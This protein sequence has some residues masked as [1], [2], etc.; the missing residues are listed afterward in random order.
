[1]KKRLFIFRALP[2]NRDSRV[3]R[4]ENTQGYNVTLNTWEDQTDKALGLDKL[5]LDRNKYSKV[6]SYPLY[7]IYLFLYSLCKI[8]NEDDVICM[9]LDTFLPVFIGSFFKKNKIYFDIVDPIAE[10]KFKGLWFNFIF[11]YMEIFLLKYRKYNIIPNYNRIKYY[12]DKYNIKIKKNKFQVIENIPVLKKNE[13]MKQNFNLKNKYMIGYFGT[14]EKERGLVELINYTKKKNITLLIAGDGKL[15]DFIVKSSVNKN[16]D[17]IGRYKS[18]DIGELFQKINFLWAYYSD[19][20]FLHKYASPNKYYEH[21]AFKT[22]II[23]NKYVPQSKLVSEFATG[24]VID[25]N[26]TDR[27]LTYMVKKIKAYK[28]DTLN[29]SIWDQKY[30]NYKIILKD[31][32]K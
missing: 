13:Q 30:A 23:I 8:K 25:D 17:Y 3:I 20:I 29:F 31:N 14:L 4:Y 1:L 10:T 11:D 32:N 5:K 16:I 6:F 9:E 27:N 19:K 12:E 7:L 21:L 28:Y 26:L 2:K 22:P 15:K 18:V 24:I